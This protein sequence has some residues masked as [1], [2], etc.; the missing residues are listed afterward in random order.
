MVRIFARIFEN[1]WDKCP[2]NK[3]FYKF[4]FVLDRVE[5]RLRSSSNIISVTVPSS[6]YHF[7]W[8]LN[9]FMSK[10]NF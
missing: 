10:N 8:G 5:G 3:K 9:F 4:V 2:T 7:I 6:S 1:K